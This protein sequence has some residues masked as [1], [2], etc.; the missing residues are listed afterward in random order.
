[1]DGVLRQDTFTGAQPLNPEPETLIPQPETEN[2]Q[3]K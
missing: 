1:M 2:A 3:L